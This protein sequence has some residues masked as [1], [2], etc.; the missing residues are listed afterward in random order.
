MTEPKTRQ[1][2][3]L[4]RRFLKAVEAASQSI[5]KGIDQMLEGSMQ[6]PQPIPVRVR[7]LSRR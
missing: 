5:I 7:P 2:A 6:A 1:S 3:P 4:G